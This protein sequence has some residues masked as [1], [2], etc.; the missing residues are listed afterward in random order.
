M[1]EPSSAKV[2]IKNHTKE[3]V[4]AEDKCCGNCRY[5]SA[6]QYPDTIFC[7]DKFADND[8]QLK[9]IFDVC[10]EWEFKEQGC[11][12]LDAAFKALPKR[13]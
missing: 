4:N 7:F 2:I 9:S 8:G 12:C 13:K 10:N 5:H 1:R 11:F 3:L 6:Y